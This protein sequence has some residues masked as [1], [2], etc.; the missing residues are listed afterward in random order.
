MKLKVDPKRIQSN[1][2]LFDVG[3]YG[4]TAESFSRRVLQDHNIK[5]K[6]RE[7]TLVKAVVYKD[8]SW[9]DIYYVAE[10]TRDV[11]RKYCIEG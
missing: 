2:V 4:I 5:I 1:I 7:K 11:V 9:N 3:S 10:A 8:V 6:A